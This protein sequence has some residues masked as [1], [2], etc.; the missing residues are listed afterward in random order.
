MSDKSFCTVETHHCPLCGAVHDIGIMLHKR[1]RPVF[2]RSTCTGESPCP[3]CLALIES[4]TIFLLEAELP[5][6]AGNPPQP[7]GRTARLTTETFSRIL[8]GPI[9]PKGIALVSPE[10]FSLLQ[11]LA[12]AAE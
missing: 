5:T 4:G 3:N 1:L 6:A 12:G 7:T 8:S 10:I 9:P 11:T 2:A